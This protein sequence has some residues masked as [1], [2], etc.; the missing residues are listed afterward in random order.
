MKVFFSA[1]LLVLFAVAN[2]A[3]KDT[4]K[5]HLVEFRNENHGVN[6]VR[7]I[8]D[9]SSYY[10]PVSERRLTFDYPS[11]SLPNNKL[12]ISRSIRPARGQARGAPRKIVGRAP[13]EFE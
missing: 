12:D 2:A 13:P 10:V 7:V 6:E 9:A 8:C 3:D 11:L 5:D 4:L 1:S